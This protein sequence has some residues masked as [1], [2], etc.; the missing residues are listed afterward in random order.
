MAGNQTVQ[1]RCLLCLTWLRQD[2]EQGWTT[3]CP[4][5]MSTLSH[6]ATLRTSKRLDYKRGKVSTF[7]HLIVSQSSTEQANKQSS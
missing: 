1:V 3:N 4:G 2:W 6:L 7:A 5:K